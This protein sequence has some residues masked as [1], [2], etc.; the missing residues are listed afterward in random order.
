MRLFVAIDLPDAARRAIGAKQQRIRMALADASLT[1]VRAEQLHLTLVFI[2]EVADERG[3]SFMTAM[4]Q[5]IPH[6]RFAMTFGATGVFPPHGAPRVLW[7]GVQEGAR[8][9]V[10]LQAHVA[11]R[12]APLGVAPESRPFSPHLTLARWRQ[13][14]AA[15]R[16][17][18]PQSDVAAVVRIDVAAVTLFQSRLS[19]S[20]PA[21][22]ALAAAPLLQ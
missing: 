5:P 8:E 13:P 17:R 6:P 4:Q 10:A 16:R 20:G 18:L 21:Y 2:G 1:W 14:R 22:T 11:S 9:T 12:L 15:D 19:S 3:P 7:V